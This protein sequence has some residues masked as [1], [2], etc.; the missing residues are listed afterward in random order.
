MTDL[1]ENI[2]STLSIEE[3]REKSRKKYVLKMFIVYVEYKNSRQKQQIGDGLFVCIDNVEE[4]LEIVWE[5]SQEFIKREIVI[6]PVENSQSFST[7]EVPDIND[8]YK[9]CRIVDTVAH[10]STELEIIDDSRLD[11]WSDGRRLDLHVYPYGTSI[12]TASQWKSIHKGVNSL[13]KDVDKDKSGAATEEEIDRIV[14]RLKEEHSEHFSAAYITWRIWAEWLL[15]KRVEEHEHYIKKPP[16]MN[17]VKLFKSPNSSENAL[18]S[19]KE[20]VNIAVDL[21]MGHE[22]DVDRLIQRYETVMASTRAK[23]RTEEVFFNEL[24]EFKSKITGTKSALESVDRSLSV[25]ENPVSLDYYEKIS[26]QE[27][28]DHVEDEEI[29]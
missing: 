2:D 1:T 25:A 13:V 7:K 9:F 20:N 19:H 23:L 18:K 27:D 6:N 26:N 24:L 29:I 14:E 22:A 15:K 16:P 17:I 12:I 11:F 5:K 21:T 10:S 28:I 4:F 3:I 8:V